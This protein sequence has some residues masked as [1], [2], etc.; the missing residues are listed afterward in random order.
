MFGSSVL[1]A[2]NRTS[3]HRPALFGGRVTSWRV[4][5]YLLT[6]ELLF[7]P[8]SGA[9][10]EGLVAVGG[11]ASPAR[12]ELAY[13][14]GIFPWPM[15]GMPLLWFS[16]DPR[17][18]LLPGDV[19]L[20]RSLKRTIRR[21]RFEIRMDTRFEDVVAAC[22][23]QPRPGQSGTWITDELAD[24]FVGLHRRGLAHSVEAYGDGELVGGLYGVSLGRAFFGESMFARESDAS[25]V[26]FV[27]LL[28]HVFG[29]W[30]FHFVDCQVYTDH[31]ATFG[32]ADV[33]R[34][35]FLGA[36]D[37]AAQFPTRRGP[38]TIE[39]SPAE[40]VAELSD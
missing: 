5:V 22:A 33:R 20:S 39:L 36:L 25:K 14:E 10:S 30:G 40:A 8:P 35:E 24:G 6:E 32:A 28:G 34:R 21:G 12:L 1:E 16:P 17:F 37:R 4:P 27:T 11:D 26:A 18:L 9:T 13:R 31:L 7:P 19:H 23:A 2:Q 15:R 38:W 3:E 29:P